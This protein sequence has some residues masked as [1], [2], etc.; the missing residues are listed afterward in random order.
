MGFV[1]KHFLFTACDGRITYKNKMRSRIKLLNPRWQTGTNIAIPVYL[2]G[3]S[4]V[5][6]R[7]YRELK[8]IF[9]TED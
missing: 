7:S 5:L 8:A 4:K 2:S 9:V 6:S 3:K 1:E